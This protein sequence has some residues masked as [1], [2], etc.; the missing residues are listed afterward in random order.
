M[1]A[2][3]KAEYGFVGPHFAFWEP[4]SEQ[5]GADIAKHSPTPLVIPKEQ[6]GAWVPMLF[7]GIGLAESESSWATFIITPLEPNLTRIENRVRVANAST[8]EFSKQSAKSYAFWRD[9][10]G[11]K[12]KAEDS[13]ADD[14]MTGGDFTAED[15]YA[16]EQ[17]QKS[18]ASPHFEVSPASK[19]ESPVV[20]HQ[21]VVLDWMEGRT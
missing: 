12:Y 4:P 16:C 15:I 14:P 6:A 9:N 3:A 11:G 17:Q 18:L 21:Q 5:Y 8:W 1:Y 2:H 10:F 7:P 20:D 19:G 13:N